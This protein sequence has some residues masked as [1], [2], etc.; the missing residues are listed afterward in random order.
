MQILKELDWSP[1][2]IS[3]KTGVV[4]TFISF[5]LG[6]FG[7]EESGESLSGEKGGNRW[8]PDASDGSAPDCGGILPSSAVQ[9]EEA[10]WGIPF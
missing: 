5:F 9:Q 3:L 2:Y 4:A 6:I 1:L 10:S 7:R 8:N